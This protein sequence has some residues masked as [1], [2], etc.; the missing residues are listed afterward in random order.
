MKIHHFILNFNIKIG[1][2][3]LKNKELF[4]QFRNVLKLKVGEIVVLCDGQTNEGTTEVK[5][6]GE[7][8]IVF[9]ITEINKNQN[10]PERQVI[11]YCAVLKKEN[12]ELVVQKV[13]EIG[14]AEIVPIITERTVKLNIRKDRLEKIAKEAAEQSGRGIVP[15][16]HDPIDFKKAVTGINKENLNFFM[17]QSGETFQFNRHRKSTG[18]AMSTVW[19]G[20]EGG[21]SP[22]E[23]ETAKN[24]GLEIISLGKTTLRAE[25]AAIVGTYLIIHS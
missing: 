19:V 12:F 17:D 21:W 23:L 18:L 6:Y 22:Q 13:T 7:D 1:I 15:I 5:E 11:L 2:F 16:L 24:T 9:E 10:E 14:I 25:T 20:P 8:N 4:N 3:E